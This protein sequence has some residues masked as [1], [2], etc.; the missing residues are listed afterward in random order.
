M[1][2]RRKASAAASAASWGRRDRRRAGWSWRG[3]ERR[4]QR[5]RERREAHSSVLRYAQRGLFRNSN[6]LRPPRLRRI[7]IHRTSRP[8]FIA[9]TSAKRKRA[10]TI[11]PAQILYIAADPA[12]SR[13]GVSGRFL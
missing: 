7:T 1:T 11:A 4:C 3:C 5:W 6:R 8:F 12:L 13:Y 9:R 2:L 10:G